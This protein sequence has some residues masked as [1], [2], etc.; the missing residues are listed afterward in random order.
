M[1]M[2]L[3]LD[4]EPISAVWQVKDRIGAP[5]WK[6]GVHVLPRDD[7]CLCGLDVEATAAANGFFI[8]DRDEV[9]GEYTL[10]RAMEGR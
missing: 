7:V 10:A 4:G 5:I 2:T 9:L 1:C 6:D 8:T 3:Y